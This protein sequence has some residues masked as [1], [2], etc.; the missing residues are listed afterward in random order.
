[1][2]LDTDYVEA[3]MNLGRKM[4]TLAAQYIYSSTSHNFPSTLGSRTAY[5][6]GCIALANHLAPAMDQD[7]AWTVVVVAEQVDDHLS[8]NPEA[9]DY[10]C[11]PALACRRPF[12]QVPAGL[13]T[14]ADS[15]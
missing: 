8:G 2:K 5:T 13:C 6:G 10:L 12:S 3:C 7:L 11:N 1:M 15:H 4:A 9:A 14:L